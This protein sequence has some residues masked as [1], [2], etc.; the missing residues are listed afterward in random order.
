M[1]SIARIIFDCGSDATFIWKEIREMP[2]SASACRKTLSVTSSG[3]PASS[4]PFG[5]RCASKLARVIVGI[6]NSRQ[7]PRS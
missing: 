6:P 2:P 7:R 4:A 5:P 3:L 1:A